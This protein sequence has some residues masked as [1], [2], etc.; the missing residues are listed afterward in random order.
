MDAVAQTALQ[1]AGKGAMMGAS[2]GSIIPG[3]GT[4]VGGAVGGLVGGV[5][6]YFKGKKDKTT[7]EAIAQEEEKLNAAQEQLRVAQVAEGNK[8]KQLAQWNA[9]DSQDKSYN[10]DQYS[11]LA[12]T[13]TL[14]V[15]GAGGVPVTAMPQAS[16]TSTLT[17]SDAQL[18]ALGV[19]S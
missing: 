4:V 14:P 11:E 2:V 8:Q 1:G 9:A 12:G 13:S 5:G 7:N 18:K 10:N 6:G 17:S 19:I 16:N 15:S 3:L